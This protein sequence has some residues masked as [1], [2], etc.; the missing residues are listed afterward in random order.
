MEFDPN[1]FEDLAWWVEQDRKKSLR[2]IK[3]IKEIQR[4]PF[5]GTG[6]PEPL[7]HKLEGGRL[8]ILAVCAWHDKVHL[9]IRNFIGQNFVHLIL[10]R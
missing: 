3:L 2:I 10:P 4:D 5:T 8:S 6:K 7:K 9:Y 1:G